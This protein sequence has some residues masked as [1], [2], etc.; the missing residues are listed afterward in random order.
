MS[1]LLIYLFDVA[2]SPIVKDG[3]MLNQYSN[4]PDTIKF[5]Y[6]TLLPRCIVGVLLMDNNKNLGYMHMVFQH[7]F[8][9]PDSTFVGLLAKIG[10]Y[11]IIYKDQGL[12]EYKREDCYLALVTRHARPNGDFYVIAGLDQVQLVGDIEAVKTL[13]TL[14]AETYGNLIRVRSDAPPW[15]S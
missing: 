2:H 8:F 12:P 1:K 11:E 9:L 5:K 13:D 7:D 4:T 6:K 15:G 14:M 3:I 10:E